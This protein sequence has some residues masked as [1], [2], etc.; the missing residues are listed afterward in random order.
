MKKTKSHPDIVIR[1][2]AGT[3]K[4]F[5]LSNRYL[6]QLQAGAAPEQMLAT[7]FTRKAA[8]EILERILI[9]LAEA[10]VQDDQCR[11]LASFLKNPSLTQTRCLQL[12]EQLVR[13]LHRVR[14]S[15]LDAFFM[16]IASSFT[17]ELGMPPGWCIL[18]D[19][20][21]A[22]MRSRA[23]EAILQQDA[24]RDVDRL[25]HLLTKGEAGRSVSE[26]IR[27]TVGN[28]YRVFLEADSGAWENFPEPHYLSSEDLSATIE[29]LR[30]VDLSA[31]KRLGKACLADCERAAAGDWEAFI[32]TGPAAK[33]ASGQV[34]YYRKPIPPEALDGYRKLLRHARAFVLDVLAKQTK[35]THQLLEKFDAEYRRL[36][37]DARAMRFE[38][39][40]RL[41]ARTG[42][43]EGNR[44][45]TF[46]LDGQISHLLLDEF[47]DTSLHQWQ[48]IRPFAKH[49]VS[50]QD[51][52]KS[53]FCVG[54]LKQ[55][56]YGWRGGIAEI[57]DA[58]DAQL[59]GL[60]R[61]SLDCSYRSSQPVIDTVNTVFTHMT[62]HKH[63]EDSAPAVSQWQ[64]Y[65][66]EHKT[67]RTELSGYTCLVT[68]PAA[69]DDGSPSNTT[70]EFAAGRIVQIVDEVPGCSI[71]VLV[72]ANKAVARL[73]FELRRLGVSASEE[74]GNPLTDSAAVQL[75]LSLLRLADHPGDT[76]ARFHVARSPLGTLL[77][78]TDHRDNAA[79]ERLA[80]Q[81]RRLL[82]TDGYGPAVYE[83][84]SRLADSCS[85]RDLSRL[86]Q[87]VELAHDYEPAAT[88]RPG[89][90]VTFVESQRL[91]D[92]TSDDV[93]V[94][95]VHQA[96]GLQFDV[97]VLPEL[98]VR[99]VGQPPSHVVGQPTPADPVD[100]IC[101]YRSADIR[102][103]LPDDIQRLFTVA[104]ERTIAETL[105]GLYVALT[106]PVH[107]LHMIIAPS[108][109][110]E[111]KL[112]KTNAG[113]LRAALTDS[114]PVAPETVLYEHGDPHWYQQI[115]V[116][117]AETAS[118][119][120]IQFAPAEIRLAPMP[121]GRKRGLARAAPSKRE[122]GSRVRID[123]ILR[124]GDTAALN[125]GTLIHAWF[126]QMLWLEDGVPEETVLRRVAETV[127]AAG[128]DIDRLIDEYHSM[129]RSPEIARAMSRDSYQPPR[130][131][132]LDAA[133][134]EE[135]ARAP[136]AMDVRNERSFAIR[137]GNTIV[138]GSIDRLVLMSHGDR[139]VAADIIDFKTD[140]IAADDSDALAERVEYY[141][142]QLETYR[143]AV[144]RLYN[145]PLERISARL[146]ML[147]TGVVAN[148]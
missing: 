25:M 64:S 76:I 125:R 45:L 93:R 23:I 6:A 128:L 75:I 114:A 107:A 126:E 46:R 10:S 1:A 94:M 11:Q 96:K 53:F 123:H 113:L 78:L 91:S 44:H 37:H 129:L 36:K 47:Q 97:V 119:P 105:C 121:E 137:E 90:F 71:G 49:V 56:I 102:A 68:A 33:V 106:R 104:T 29:E 63:L 5:Q 112:P 41:L 3:G 141:R 92:P 8:G 115:G 82:V 39:V 2:S 146:L 50:A 85:R 100:R 32:G 48:V 98:D 122:G 80:S 22:Q 65:F 67:A 77:G 139:V 16:Q 144:A 110:K 14:V 108:K 116:K 15:T 18:D 118:N 120:D 26:L 140:S 55:A 17:L 81:V 147:G 38:D 54:D 19:A 52:T 30:T 103:I 134:L 95:T 42:L 35:A 130:D 13:R 73:V 79:T 145:L 148:L 24:T 109:P 61:E 40:T 70:L 69:P 86:Q 87:L 21:D 51:A 124:L 74:G 133:V 143:P 111:R 117:Q 60:T 101:L 99:L 136:I 43:A 131:L 138:S 83:W 7:T 62:D 27:S 89:D 132:N 20:S 9:R 72:R 135:L 12:L 66:N 84:V 31:N 34:E 57:F 59:K 142:G 4:T 127:G 28:L 58:V 88:L